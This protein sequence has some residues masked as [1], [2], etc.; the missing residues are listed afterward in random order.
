VSK[1]S[2][3]KIDKSNLKSNQVNW[4][5]RAREEKVG[6]LIISFGAAQS[7]L[8]SQSPSQNSAHVGCSAGVGCLCA[9][10]LLCGSDREQKIK[11]HNKLKAIITRLHVDEILFFNLSRIFPVCW[12]IL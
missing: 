4:N 1:T 11:T 6:F 3:V 12:N 7:D 5:R 2:E 9:F 10:G 8:Q